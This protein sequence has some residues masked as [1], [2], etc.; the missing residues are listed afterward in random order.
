MLPRHGT[1]RH[2]GACSPGRSRQENTEDADPSPGRCPSPLI[3][4][5]PPCQWALC[6]K[7]CALARCRADTALSFL[8][9]RIDIVL[10][11]QCASRHP[12]LGGREAPPRQERHGVLRRLYDQAGS[13]L[14]QPGA[15]GHLISIDTRPKTRPHS[16]WVPGSH[17]DS[18]R[19]EIS[20]KV[21]GSGIVHPKSSAECVVFLIA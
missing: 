1:P 14:N 16:A 19:M 15:P 8:V 12:V 4:A 13:E 9:E 17:G 11:N 18:R 20:G 21:S 7:S 5:Y 10:V 6:N 2:A 3:G